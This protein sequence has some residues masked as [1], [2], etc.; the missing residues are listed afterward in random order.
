[1]LG[2]FKSQG[3]SG[4]PALQL[5]VHVHSSHARMRFDETYCSLVGLT[6]SI[7]FNGVSG[8]RGDSEDDSVGRGSLRGPAARAVMQ[9]CES[10]AISES[11]IISATR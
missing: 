3:T 2:T 7:E 6:R 8:E 5:S 4:G 11:G 10:T 1:M 9:R